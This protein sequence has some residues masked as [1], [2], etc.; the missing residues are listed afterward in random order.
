VEQQQVGSAIKS[1]RGRCM[2]SSGGEPDT[3]RAHQ[4][5]ENK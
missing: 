4:A 1:R 2:G 5:G 3:A